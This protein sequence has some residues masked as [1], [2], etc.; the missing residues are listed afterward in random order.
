MSIGEYLRQSRQGRRL[1][2]GEV[3]EALHIR[4]E[5]LEALEADAWDK[6]PGDVYGLGFLRSYARYLELD[7]DALVEYRKRL[8][9]RAAPAAKDSARLPSVPSR[10][11]RRLA[12][13][14]IQ[15]QGSSRSRRSARGLRPSSPEPRVSSRSVWGAAI[16]LAALFAIGLYK[17]PKAPSHDAVAPT[18]RPVP[19][20][21]HVKAPRAPTRPRSIASHHAHH[22]SAPP[23]ATVRL[24]ANNPATGQLLYSVNQTPVSVTVTFTGPCWTEEWINGATS[25]PYGHVYAA[26]QRLAISAT[27]SVALKFGTRFVNLMVNGTAVSLPDPT[28]HVLT[29]TF[30]HIS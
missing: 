3:S 13:A 18:H 28:I 10:R 23:I 20:H 25:N 19:H 7:A 15:P 14:K 5:Y 6:L 4:V 17:L 11:E 27:H 21:R 24:A 12:K 16:V 29:V 8:I 2:L 9:Q 26:G 1:T 22:Q 30:R